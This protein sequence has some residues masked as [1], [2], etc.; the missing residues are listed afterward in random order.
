MLLHQ[1]I[2]GL[3]HK[4]Y[5]FSNFKSTKPPQVLCYSE[6]HLKSYQL[7]NVLIQ[8]YNLVAKFWRNTF[9]NGGVCIYTH[10]SI[11]FSSINV[12][13]FCKVKDLEA[14]DIKVHLP[15]Y[16]FYIV[17]IHPVTLNIF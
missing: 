1:N 9:K 17:V 6:H 8:I 11:Q 16:T 12:V 2:R 13:H 3:N 4:N 7:N 5:E 10:D 15:S 14:C